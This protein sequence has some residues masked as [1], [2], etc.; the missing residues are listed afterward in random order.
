MA[1]A[2]LGPSS[3]YR[4]NRHA[5]PGS[6]KLEAQYEDKG[7]V[8]SR[9]G[10]FYHTIGEQALD[11]CLDAIDWAMLP[12]AAAI[13]GGE[14]APP[15]EEGLE[16]VQVYI[17]YVNGVLDEEAGWLWLEQRVEIDTEHW[18]TAD[19]IIY[20]PLS[21]TLHVIDYK[22]GSGVFV[23]VVNNKQ[24]MSY[25]VGAAKRLRDLAEAG[26]LMLD[27]QPVEPEIN[28]VMLTIV[29]PRNTGADDEPV[30]SWRADGSDLEEWAEDIHQDVLAALDPDAPVLP[31]KWC[32]FCKAERD[33]PA[34]NITIDTGSMHFPFGKRAATV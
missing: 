8:Y 11:A 10:T 3:R 24:A 7:N 26:E 4:W 33:C 6:A 28:E 25:A 14:E 32:R 34:K 29:Q 20:Q 5:C 27:G 19:V 22:H 13:A 15:T 2:L 30:R 17:D 18:G 16:A 9:E 31:G 1:H 12:V 23:P 21:K